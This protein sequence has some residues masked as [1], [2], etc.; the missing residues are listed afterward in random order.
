MA[1]FRAN[2]LL[3]VMAVSPVLVILPTLQG[4]HTLIAHSYLPCQSWLASVLPQRH[5]LI[6]SMN[7]SVG[8][9]KA[10]EWNTRFIF[11]LITW[12]VMATMI[13]AGR[14]LEAVFCLRD[15]EGVWRLQ[16]SPDDEC[17]DTWQRWLQHATGFG[18]GLLVVVVFPFTLLYQLRRIVR[19]GRWDVE[20]E[21]DRYGNFYAGRVKKKLHALWLCESQQQF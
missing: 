11:C 19:T 9:D 16:A 13:I 6:P 1:V 2:A 5:W 20:E 15:A 4:F 10:R 17:F 8:H 14:C 12:V 3:I 18:G 21:Q 7:P